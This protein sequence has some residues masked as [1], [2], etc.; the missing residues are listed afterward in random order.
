MH[1]MTAAPARAEV[2]VTELAVRARQRVFH[3]Q[4]ALAP[5]L[6]HTQA[7]VPEHTPHP[8]RRPRQDRLLNQGGSRNTRGAREARLRRTPPPPRFSQTLH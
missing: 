2:Q 3:V 4:R 6:V 7:Q 8:A 1:A 5:Q